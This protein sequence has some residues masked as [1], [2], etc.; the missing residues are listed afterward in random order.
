MQLKTILNRV[1]KHRSFVYSAIR[2]VEQAEGAILEVEIRARANSRPICSGCNRTGAG[3]DSLD[4]RRFEFVPLWGIK[5]FFLYAMRRVDC[6]SC[7]VRVETAPWAEGKHH[8]TKTSPFKVSFLVP[9]QPRSRDVGLLEVCR[10]GS[11]RLLGSAD[12][13]FVL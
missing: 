13:F 2:L 4:E 9:E 12:V 3:Y 7:G 5:V 10:A 8:I 6:L 1:E 11:R